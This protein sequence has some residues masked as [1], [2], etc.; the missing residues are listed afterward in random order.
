[1]KRLL[2]SIIASILF[3]TGLPAQAAGPV[4]A[5]PSTVNVNPAGS[6]VLTIRWRVGVLSS[7]PASIVVSSAGG[8]L[9]TGLATG[10]ALSQTVQHPG[11]GLIFVTFTERLRLDRTSAQ[12]IAQNGG[13]TYDRVFTDI[14]GSSGPTTVALRSTGGGELSF[15]DF[16]L[17]FDDD[18]NFRVV[19]KDTALTARAQITTAGKG[20]L[21]GVWQ[22]AGPSGSDGSAFRPV[23]RVR[24][25]LA[26][27]RRTVLES[28]QLPTDR[29]GIYRVRFLPDTSN[30]RAAGET[31][32]ELSYSVLAGAGQPAL[33]L[34]APDP[35]S[36]VSPATQFRWQPVGGA[37]GYRIEFLA[38]SGAGISDQR[39]AALDVLE[40]QATLRSFT[41][42]RLSGT[43]QVF[44]RVLAFDAAGDLIAASPAR[45]L[46]AVP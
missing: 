35:G 46:K 39:L 34:I 6:T 1:M 22:V 42:A 12:L 11:T 5:T 9:S 19:G 33:G 28:P 23:G 20:T 17:E 43:Q 36:A 7:I 44:W 2:Q 24:Q 16:A 8:T 40:P 38:A 13:A 37:A 45:A 14:N 41:L 21:D 32:P 18:S 30:T 27:S 4:T 31:Y 10:G 25:V 26:G 29:P 3:A 15:R